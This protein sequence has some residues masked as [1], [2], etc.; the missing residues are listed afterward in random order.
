MHGV[1]LTALNQLI[2]DSRASTKLIPEVGLIRCPGR[3]VTMPPYVA[4][5][6][7]A[8]GLT[9]RVFTTQLK[10]NFALMII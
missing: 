4:E 1:D 2:V 10:L 7:S 8:K 6:L 3:K 9:A 5:S